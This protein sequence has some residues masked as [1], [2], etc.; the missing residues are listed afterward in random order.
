[1]HVVEPGRCT[2]YIDDILFDDDPNLVATERARQRGR[3]GSGI[4]VPRRDRG[5]WV[6]T[7]DIILGKN[8]SGYPR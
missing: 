4:V 8:I 3:G 5:S 1:M 7:R 2:Y 6:V